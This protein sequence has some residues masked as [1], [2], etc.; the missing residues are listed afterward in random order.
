MGPAY[1]FL[2]LILAPHQAIFISNSV[3]KNFNSIVNSQ[4]KL[5]KN[6]LLVKSFRCVKSLINLDIKNHCNAFVTKMECKLL[7]YTTQKISGKS[8]GINPLCEIALRIL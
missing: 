8:N 6:E 3:M 1:L 7:V 5:T 4:I 2:V